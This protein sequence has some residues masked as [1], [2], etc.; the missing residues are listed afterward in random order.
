M[1][2]PVS[3]KTRMRRGLA[4][5]SGNVL[6][7]MLAWV[8]AGAMAAAQTRGKSAVAAARTVMATS[9][10][11]VLRVGQLAALVTS[12]ASKPDAV[13]CTQALSAACAVTGRNINRK[14]KA[15]VIIAT[16]P[17]HSLAAR[18]IAPM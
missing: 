14:Q 6:S 4:A 1:R 7:A 15:G 17:N 16:D 5:G 8:A 13:A 2:Q 18:T 12:R 10:L 3:P 11:S 9:P